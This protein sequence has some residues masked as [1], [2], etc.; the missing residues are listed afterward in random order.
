MPTCS[1]TPE[2]AEGCVFETAVFGLS[3]R[4]SVRRLVRALA[5]IP[6]YPLVI[7]KIDRCGKLLGVV[8]QRPGRKKG[9]ALI[10]YVT[11][12]HWGREPDRL[13][14]IGWTSDPAKLGRGFEARASRRLLDYTSGVRGRPMTLRYS[15]KAHMELGSK[16]YKARR[17]SRFREAEAD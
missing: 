4:E 12:R 15:S 17:R 8:D 5:G 11:V 10:Y 2:K 7:F 9:A 6:C 14:D 1:P 13:P 3:R 16:I